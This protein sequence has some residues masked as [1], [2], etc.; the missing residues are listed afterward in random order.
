M[1]TVPDECLEHS[2]PSVGH[3]AGVPLHPGL[4]VHNMPGHPLP[5]IVPPLV[6]HSMLAVFY[7]TSAGELPDIPQ[8]DALVLAV[9]DEV[10]AISPGVN[11]GDPINMSCIHDLK[12]YPWLTNIPART[13]TGLGSSSRRDLLSQTLHRPSSPPDANT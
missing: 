6:R 12:D 9:G 1:R 5:S 3:H 2:V 4:A 10:P 7:C 8:L 11:I 13:P